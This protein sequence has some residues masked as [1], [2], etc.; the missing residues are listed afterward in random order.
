MHGTGDYKVAQSCGSSEV[1]DAFG[2]WVYF[3]QVYILYFQM[4]SILQAMVS[5]TLVHSC[6]DSEVIH[7]SCVQIIIG[8]TFRY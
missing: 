2:M 8:Y 1:T 3:Y 7:S 6:G 4:H 5:S